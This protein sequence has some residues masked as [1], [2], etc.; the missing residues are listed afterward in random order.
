MSKNIL[1]L[2]N[3][4][5]VNKL[6]QLYGKDEATVELNFNRYQH[7]VDKFEERFELNENE[8][9][10]F[11]APGRTE[12]AGNHV[13]HQLGNVI[14]ASVDL[15]IVAACQARDD[16]KIQF[17]SEA[18]NIVET[19]DL[20]DLEPQ[21]QEIGKTPALIRGVAH[22]FNKRGYKIGGFNCY[23]TSKVAAGSGI[24]SSAAFEIL[25][26]TIFNYMYNEGKISPIEQAT[27]SQFAENVFFD[28]PSGLLDQTACAFGEVIAIDFSDK[29]NPQV[30]QIDLDLADFGY[31][32][33]ITKTDKGHS[34]LTHEYASIPND[35]QAI[36]KHFSKTYLSE[37]NPEEF[38]QVVP[39]LS[40]KFP[41]RAVLR[42]IHFFTE[43]E[44]TA[45]QLKA[46]QDKNFKRFLEL[47]NESAHSSEVQLQ[48]VLIPGNHEEQEAALALALSRKFFKDNNIEGAC[49]IHGG[50]F[51]GTI[52]AYV[53]I[54]AVEDY[55]NT[56]EASFGKDACM[57]IHIRPVG[58]IEL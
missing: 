9:R 8:I 37:V 49:R 29:E 23:S 50:G 6:E 18:Y 30:K 45:E 1:S 16:F 21:K 48:N 51:G 38:F 47:V 44:R 5:L 32:M 17:I 31:E 53:P 2:E 39:E 46:L 26:A 22:A 7:L 10:F 34:N 15:D 14:A 27:A 3:T 58:G 36:A 4:E 54:E 56:I 41:Q 20:N 57:I 25:I 24:S 13:D 40:Q 55:V 12:I 43:E 11:S 33:V 52:Q 28:K 42:A 19:I 35:M